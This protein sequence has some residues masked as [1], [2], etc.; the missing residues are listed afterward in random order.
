MAVDRFEVALKFFDDRSHRKRGH[1]STQIGV[2]PCLRNFTRRALRQVRTYGAHDLSACVASAHEN[3]PFLS[4]ADRASWSRVST[5]PR[6]SVAKVV[7]HAPRFHKPSA[8]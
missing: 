7:L 8:A 6:T 3:S 4:A 5:A 1:R 2:N